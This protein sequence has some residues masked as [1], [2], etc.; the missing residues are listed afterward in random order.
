MLRHQG[1]RGVRGAE[2][3]TFWEYAEETL[4]DKPELNIFIKWYASFHCVNKQKN[5]FSV[6]QSLD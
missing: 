1:L 4:R 2:K 6:I 5:K 3:L